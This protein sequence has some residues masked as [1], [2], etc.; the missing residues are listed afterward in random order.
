MLVLFTVLNLISYQL[1][2]A[3]DR[4]RIHITFC[5]VQGYGFEI[6]QIWIKFPVFCLFIF[7]SSVLSYISM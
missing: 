2:I 4:I 1:D 3:W 5:V 6:K 7:K